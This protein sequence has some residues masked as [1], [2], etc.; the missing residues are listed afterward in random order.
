MTPLDKA[1]R[2]VARVTVEPLGY[3]HGADRNRKLVARLVYG[4]LLE[5]R[6]LGTRRTIS[7]RLVDVY[8]YALR[9]AVN[10]ARLEKARARKLELAERRARARLRRE[11]RRDN[12]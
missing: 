3:G 11:A 1:S 2:S 5:F 6:P 7:L 4:D 12:V 10:R 8:S 9:C